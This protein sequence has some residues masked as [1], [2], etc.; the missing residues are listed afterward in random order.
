MFLVW[1]L[2]PNN[3]QSVAPEN[4]KPLTQTLFNR[5]GHVVPRSLA[6]FSA[7]VES[8][9]SFKGE[10]DWRDVQFN[11]ICKI[12]ANKFTLDLHKTILSH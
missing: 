11:T 2:N 10:D 9:T 8:P 3:P 4:Y 6:S 1:R 12:D 7:T 5:V